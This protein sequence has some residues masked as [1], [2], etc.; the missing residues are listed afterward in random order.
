M[1]SDKNRR[2]VDNMG[3]NDSD[4]EIESGSGESL[5]RRGFLK[6][7]A[8]TAGAVVLAGQST[9]AGSGDE[10]GSDST[11]TTTVEST[12]EN[13]DWGGF[14][15]D[16]E[17]VLEVESG[18]TVTVETI[19]IPRED[20]E[21]FLIE[22]G[23]AE[24]DVLDDEVRVWE[25][26]ENEGPGPHVVTGPIYIEDAEPGDILE[27][28]VKDIQYRAP[29]GIN[30][31][32]PGAGA[33]PEVFSWS[34]T[35]A[36]PMDLDAEIAEFT[37]GIDVPLDPFF[38]IMAV[39]PTPTAGRTST[40]P[41]SYF[42]GNMDNPVL[43]EGST[44]YFP[45]NADGALFWAGDGHA[46]QGNGEVC[47]TAVETS[48][49]GTFEFTLH[50]DAPRL[51]WPVGETEDHY[52]PM[53]FD[54]DLDEAMKHAVREAIA[55][56]VHQHD[57]S[58]GDAYRLCSIAVDFNISEVVDGTEI[59]HGMVPKDIFPDNRELTVEGLAEEF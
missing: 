10:E 26:V 19:T 21:E 33:L 49:T 12:P 37:N 29:Y 54:E 9:A 42:G 59:I 47:V 50:K 4:V 39:S 51:D 31:F 56:L 58:P 36:I 46:V 24:S 30:L 22:E 20:H 28:H 8:G 11:E 55:L 13:V 18:D 2:S 48:L 17:P 44:V 27:V 23:I 6:S 40:G 14:D 34:E 38:G 1:S 5:L 16:R 57:L 3:D 45:V 53:G 25:E 7:A 43:G 52:V 32:T 15:P 41:P 35:H